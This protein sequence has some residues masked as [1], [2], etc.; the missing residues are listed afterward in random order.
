MSDMKQPPATAMSKIDE[1]VELIRE[2]QRKLDELRLG[3]HLN[4]AAVQRVEAIDD[5]LHDALAALGQ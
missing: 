4:S 5:K 2:A 1:A 3:P